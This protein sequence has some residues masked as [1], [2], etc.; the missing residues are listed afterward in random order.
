VC[1]RTALGLLLN[2]ILDLES[3]D[4]PRSRG[5]H[6]S[7]VLTI[8]VGAILKTKCVPHRSCPQVRG[9]ALASRGTH[10][11]DATGSASLLLE[12]SYPQLCRQLPGKH[13]RPCLLQLPE[14]VF[15]ILAS[16]ELMA[17]FHAAN[18]HVL[19]VGGGGGRGGSGG[20]ASGGSG[21][22]AEAG[23]GRNSGGVADGGAQG[24]M[25]AVQQATRGLLQAVDGAL[26]ASRIEVAES[27]GARVRELLAV[28]D[29]SKGENLYQVRGRR[30]RR[31]GVG[32]AC[33]PM[34]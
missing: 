5:W 34:P 30:E 26:C 9:A 32:M 18:Q 16:Y 12:A 4:M 25:A 21:N 8:G 15:E 14:L 33:N 11:E 1:S 27:I 22:D 3:P 28:P 31:S 23:D 13:V 2:L 17:Q 6:R 19:E 29:M 10:P 24:H 20:T 7:S